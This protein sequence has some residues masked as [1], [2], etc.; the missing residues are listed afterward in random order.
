MTYELTDERYRFVIGGSFPTRTVDDADEYLAAALRAERFIAG[1]ARRSDEDGLHW[2]EDEDGESKP[3]DASFYGGAAGIVWFYLRLHEVTGDD[4]YRRVVLEASRYLAKHWRDVSF[5]PPQPNDWIAKGFYAGYAGIGGVLLE[6][7]RTFSDEWSRQ[8]LERIVAYYVDSA[9]HDAR[10][11]YWTGPSAMMLDGG[12]LVFLMDV[13]RTFPSDELDRLIREAGRRYAQGGV[14]TSAGGLLFNGWEGMADYTAPNYDFGTAG[15]GFVLLRLYAYTQDESYLEKALR[16]AA[17]LDEVAVRVGPGETHAGVANADGES[18]D[19]GDDLGTAMLL[20]HHIEAD[21]SL[22]RDGEGAPVFYLGMCNGPVGSSNF[23]YE[24][25]RVTG[26]DQYLERLRELGR[27]LLA[28]G[29]PL[30]YSAGL[31]NNPTYCCGQ[32]GIAHWAL[33]QTLV[34]ADPM[35]ATLAQ[36][37]GSVLLGWEERRPEGGSAW[38]IAWERVKPDLMTRRL[39]LY[40]GTAGVGVAL[41]ELYLHANGRYR[42]HRFADDAF[43]ESPESQGMERRC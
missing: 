9:R 26:D 10:G 22:E 5:Y 3:G 7:W 40:D 27:G 28:F 41:L 20:P 2:L 21:G 6:V 34:D 29:A 25:H 18:P 30:R 14:P 38:P 11:A 4:R 24:M 13:A 1:H 31:W 33:A 35:W 37:S 15:A 43:P 23:Y 42:W 16:A 17:Y 19:T 8:G 36:R 32:A 39:G 12:V